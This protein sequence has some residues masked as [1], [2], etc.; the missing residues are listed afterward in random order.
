MACQSMIQKCYRIER[1]T[2]EYLDECKPILTK[3]GAL[4]ADQLYQASNLLIH[5]DTLGHE[6]YK[7]LDMLP[8]KDNLLPTTMTS[9]LE[10]IR[11]VINHIVRVLSQYEEH[12]KQKINCNQDV[13]GLDHINVPSTHVP[14]FIADCSNP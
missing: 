9:Q 13:E 6:V 7:Y 3:T 12:L 11:C 4:I 5:D 1:E 2:K 8:A 14:C 10:A